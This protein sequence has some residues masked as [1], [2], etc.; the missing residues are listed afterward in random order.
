MEINVVPARC[1]VDVVDEKVS[2]FLK[3]QGPVNVEAEHE[4]LEK[5]MEETQK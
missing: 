3:L 4:K 1:A 5:K 2:V